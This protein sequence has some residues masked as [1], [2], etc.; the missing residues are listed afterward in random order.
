MGQLPKFNT[1]NEDLHNFNA[2]QCIFMIDHEQIEN[3]SFEG[4]IDY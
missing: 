3:G 1:E 4:K 2:K